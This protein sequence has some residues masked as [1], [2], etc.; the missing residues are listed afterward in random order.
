M[1]PLGQTAAGAAERSVA[2]RPPRLR[3]DLRFS[4]I[5]GTMYCVMVGVGESYLVLFALKAGHGAVDA[6]LIAT[7]P[8][9]AG[10]LLQL[11]SPT[12][13]RSS[14]RWGSWPRRAGRRCG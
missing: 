10:A 3:K 13:V 9:L 5:D 4:V 12:G 8:L 1:V 7:V 2:G 11:L 14:S 6:G